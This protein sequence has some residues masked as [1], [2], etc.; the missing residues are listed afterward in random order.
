MQLFDIARKAPMEKC[1]LNILIYH[2]VLRCSSTFCRQFRMLSL[3]HFVYSF[4]WENATFFL[5]KRIEHASVRDFCNYFHQ[6]ATSSHHKSMG[7]L[8]PKKKISSFNS[9]TIYFSGLSR[10]QK[11]THRDD[12]TIEMIASFGAIFDSCV[13][14]MNV[15]VSSLLII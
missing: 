3:F 1:A 7:I 15:R 10:V 5:A 11:K 12:D 14:R 9:F 8:V 2:I 4:N 13:S 6:G